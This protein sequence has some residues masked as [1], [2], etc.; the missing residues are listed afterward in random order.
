[1]GRSGGIQTRQWG[2]RKLASGCLSF[3]FNGAGWRESCGAVGDGGQRGFKFQKKM[4]H[5][6]IKYKEAKMTLAKLKKKNEKTNG[7]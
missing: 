6:Q 7:E 3:K 2:N 1:M 4:T 5:D